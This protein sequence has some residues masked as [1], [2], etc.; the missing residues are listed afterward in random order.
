MRNEAIGRIVSFLRKM[1]VADMK[2]IRAH[3]KGRAIRSLFRDLRKID[4]RSSF[5]HAGKY[6]ALRETPVFDSC[7]LWFHSDIGFVREGT[8]KAAT[9]R[10]IQESDI[11][12]TH[13]ELENI[14]RVRVHNT[15]LD[16][17]NEKKLARKKMGATFAYFSTEKKVLVEQ[18]KKRQLALQSKAAVSCEV[19]GWLVI[20]I[21]AEIIHVYSITLQPQEIL[22]GLL[23]KGIRVT[24]QQVQSVCDK[25]EF[26]KNPIL[27]SSKNFTKKLAK[28][29]PR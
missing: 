2:A 27:P 29:F 14:F 25:L 8:L 6:Y 10:L 20:E 17:V 11:G 5:T 28:P 12:C 18:M 16:L 22:A 15:L 13:E 19:S 21:L 4:C 9:L 3:L 23:K 7:G 24:L 1:R 26:K